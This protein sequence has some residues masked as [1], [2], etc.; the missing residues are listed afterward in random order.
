MNIYLTACSHIF[1]PTSSTNPPLPE[2]SGHTAAVSDVAVVHPTPQPRSGFLLGATGVEGGVE[3]SHHTRL[4]PR[5]LLLRHR[6]QEVQVGKC[7][8]GSFTAASEVL[9][10]SD[11][12]FFLLFSLFSLSFSFSTFSFFFFP[13]FFFFF[14]LISSFSFS[15]FFLS[16]FSFLE[17]SVSRYSCKKF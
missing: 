11:V 5:V 4:H 10:F 7:E 16:F 14:F 6:Q 1:S 8:C 3:K 15:F 2:H 13:F 9:S 12:F 17:V